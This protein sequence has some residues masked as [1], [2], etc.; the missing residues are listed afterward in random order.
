MIGILILFGI[1][2]VK[3]QTLVLLHADGTTTDVELATQPKVTFENNKVLITSTILNMEYP[4]QDV[5]RFTFKSSSTGIRSTKSD[6]GYT[7]ENGK[8]VFHGVSNSDKIGVY[9]L[10][11]IR[12][13][14]KIKQNGNH[15]TLSLLSLSPGAYI[16]NVNGKTSKII[17]R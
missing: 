10:K 17:K 3:A 2:T 1:T 13:P 9:T 7:N 6:V 5:L 15:A 14:V 16:I 4:K 8:L 12:V 11:G